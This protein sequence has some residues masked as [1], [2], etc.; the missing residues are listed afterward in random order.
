MSKCINCGKEYDP[1]ETARVFG[2][3][4]WTEIYCSAQC[5]TEAQTDRE[6]EDR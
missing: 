5:Y 1:E 2:D 3:M 6:L 4:L